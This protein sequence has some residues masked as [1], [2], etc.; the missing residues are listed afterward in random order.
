M[1]KCTKT[2][3]YIEPV[4]PAQFNQLAN[5]AQL[6][7]FEK[8]QTKFKTHGGKRKGAGRK[9]SKNKKQRIELWIERLKIKELGGKKKIKQHLYRLLAGKAV[10]PFSSNTNWR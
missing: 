5:Q 10:A 4:T 7:L 9:M 3:F 8:A 1:K 6:G 2:K